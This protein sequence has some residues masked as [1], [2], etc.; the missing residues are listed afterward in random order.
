MFFCYL[1]TNNVENFSLINTKK[2]KISKLFVLKLAM[3]FIENIKQNQTNFT[4]VRMKTASIRDVIETAH[5]IS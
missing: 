1:Q 2:L 4:K 3:F 5:P